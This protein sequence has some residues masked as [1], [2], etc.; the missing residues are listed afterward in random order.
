LEVW[1]ARTHTHTHKTM[2]V[3]TYTCAVFV[4]V[5]VCIRVPL[6]SK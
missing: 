3:L 1:T 4:R 6:A 5:D 2:F